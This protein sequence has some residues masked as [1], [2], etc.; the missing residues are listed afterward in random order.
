MRSNS[1]WQGKQGLIELFD[2]DE[3]MHGQSP[4]LAIQ[5]VTGPERNQGGIRL[6]SPP[7][8]WLVAIRSI[9][10]GDGGDLARRR[11]NRQ[12]LTEAFSL[13]DHLPRS[14]CEKLQKFVAMLP[15]LF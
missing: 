4:T 5:T 12:I 15:V 8:L 9:C 3:R 10:N 7:D 2:R 13:E 14:F 6:L 1:F 11:K